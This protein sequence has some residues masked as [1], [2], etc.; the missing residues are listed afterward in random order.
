MVL[1]IAFHMIH[2]TCRPEP[3]A[4]QTNLGMIFSRIL[5]DLEHILDICYESI[6]RWIDTQM[7]RCLDGYRDG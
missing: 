4:S 5:A 6:D 7:D 2:I 3:M 1:S